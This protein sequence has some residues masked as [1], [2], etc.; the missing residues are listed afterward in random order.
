MHK[1]V[2]D[3]H[4]WFMINLRSSSPQE[5]VPSLETISV[6][7]AATGRDPQVRSVVTFKVRQGEDILCPRAGFR[8]DWT[9]TGFDAQS[10]GIWECCCDHRQESNDSNHKVGL[11]RTRK[12]FF[13]KLE[14]FLT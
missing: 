4:D 11:K 1:K 14:T 12:F 10:P 3:L 2:K 8:K 7:E 13:F 9:Q 5:N 6:V